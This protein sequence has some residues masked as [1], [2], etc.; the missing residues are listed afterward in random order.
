MIK[1]P[2]KSNGT[3]YD[4]KYVHLPS[5]K[6]SKLYILYILL[7]SL[8]FA[9]AQNPALAKKYFDDGDFEKAAYEYELLM[10][11]FAYND[12]YINNLFRS[13]QALKKYKSADSLV[14]ALKPKRKPALWV[15]QGY[16]WQVQKD[17]LKAK[18]YYNKAIKA[19]SKRTY[20][21][22]AVGAAFQKYYL[23][24]EALQVY[25]QA[26]K[27]DE[28]ANFYLQVAQIYAE[29]NR[30]DKTF[31]NYLA[32]VE[33]NEHSFRMSK[34]YLS[35]YITQDPENKANI[36]LKNQLIQKIKENPDYR[37]YNLLHWLYLQ[38]KDYKKAFFQLKS[39]YRKEM[40]EISEI[41]HLANT[42]R[43]AKKNDE[44][45][46]I[47]QFVIDENNN[48]TYVELSKL[49]LLNMETDKL[50]NEEEKLNLQSTFEQ[51][52]NEGWSNKSRFA[53][54]LLYAD[55]LAFH[56]K[57]S[58]EALQLLEQTE[59]MP[60]RNT[61]KAAINLKKAD[62]YLYD[63]KFNQ[64]LVLYTQV[65]L[66]FTNNEIGH[67]ATYKIA[68]S[69]FFKG[70]IDWAHSQLN[71]IKSVAS[72]LISNDAIDLDLVIINNKEQGDTL[73]IGLK[74]FA[75]AK[76]EIFRK[77]SN[78]ASILLDSMKINFKGQQIYDDVLWEQAKI[79]EQQQKF[80]SALGNYQEILNGKEDLFK[81]DAIFRMARIYEVEKEDEE[82]AKEYYKK[83]I[84][85][86]PASY[87][88]VDARKYYRKLRGDKIEP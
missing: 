79:Y 5:M 44:A 21:V 35:K 69:S 42:A 1:T 26:M 14:T 34:Y 15:L 63:K 36:I 74:K 11:K 47:Y 64:A 71:V 28:K 19:A 50:L 20:Y 48:R 80:D 7:F 86:Y 43:F 39:L 38:Q 72:D 68:R 53:L 81:D 87:W 23:L 49:A 52:L 78:K 60:L 40:A 45:T 51:Y 17:T 55:F 41:Y 82:K 8:S 29:K 33:Q 66:D 88:F 25:E 73:Q 57:K 54:N 85:D 3:V 65:Q 32:Y 76:F 27:N 9:Q 31:E 75:E 84:I 56:L 18:K 61:Q 62:I 13:Y 24:N 30:L 12:Q 70:D 37:W 59:K 4:K 2:I 77:N 46:T 16:N 83:I 58:D 67:Q 10:H 22:Y 6:K